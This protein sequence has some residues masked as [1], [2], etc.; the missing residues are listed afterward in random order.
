ME[1]KNFLE[2][3]LRFLTRSF[4]LQ[5]EEKWEES[6]DNLKKSWEILQ[7]MIGLVDNQPQI[8]QIL[9]QEREILPSLVIQNSEGLSMDYLAP[10]VG[11]AKKVKK[12]PKQK[13]LWTEEEN[14]K[15]SEALKIYG[16]KDL[17]SLSAFIGSRSISQI[18]SKLQK[19][20]LKRTVGEKGLNGK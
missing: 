7:K 20:A 4:R 14:N 19:L 8:Q 2:E 10:P 17:K 6:W 1:D 12:K 11:V 18:R 15:L 5:C 3:N 16:N 13:N 9:S